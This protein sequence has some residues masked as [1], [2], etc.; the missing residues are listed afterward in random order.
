MTD[1]EYPRRNESLLYDLYRE[2]EPST[3]EIADTLGCTQQ[4]VSKRMQRLNIPR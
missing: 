1:S 2:Q 4:T 3:V